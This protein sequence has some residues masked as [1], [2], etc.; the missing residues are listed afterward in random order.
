MAN[1][2]EGP[3]PRRRS[4]RSFAVS[5]IVHA[6]RRLSPP[7]LDHLYPLP[8]WTVTLEEWQRLHHLDLP[9]L[10]DL[11]IARELSRLWTRITYEWPPADDWT[12]E[13]RAA[14]F[15]ERDRRRRQKPGVR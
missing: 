1:A 9:A 6:E 3:I 10:S 11:E 14:L 2:A 13:R 4:D 8:R 5:S 15:A 12:W 7:Y